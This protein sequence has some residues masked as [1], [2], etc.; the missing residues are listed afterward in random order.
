VDICN[1]FTETNS[2]KKIIFGPL[3]GLYHLSLVPFKREKIIS[4]AYA[5]PSLVQD[6]SEQ[7]NGTFMFNTATTKTHQWLSHSASHIHILTSY[8]TKVSKY[9]S[10]IYILI[11]QMA[12]SKMLNNAEPSTSTWS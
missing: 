6:Y 2:T 10:S 8:F 11:L 12:L 4:M 5:C 7:F 9:Y 1:P 3:S